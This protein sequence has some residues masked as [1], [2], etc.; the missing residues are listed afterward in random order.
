MRNLI[1]LLLLSSQLFAQQ[2][3]RIEVL[4]LGDNGHHVPIERIPT[5]MAALGPKG[6]NFTYTDQLED[7]NKTTLSKYD[8]LMIFANW[9][10]ISSEQEKALLDFVASGKG[11]LPIHCASY[12][13]RNSNEYVKLVGGQFWR[14]TMDSIT[15]TTIK[16]EHPI[17]QGLSSFTAY[18]ETYLHSQLQADNNVLATREIKSDQYKDRP[19]SKTEPY[20]WTRTYGKGKI[21]YTAYGHDERTWQKTGFQDLLYNAI[22]WSVNDEAR[23]A[24]SN[25][26]PTPFEYREA[27]LPNYEQRPGKQLQQLPLSPEESMK[28][29]QVPV[30]FNI[31]TFAAEPNVM[32]PIAISWDE[33]GRMFVLI[34]KDYPNERK[35]TGGSDYILICEDTDKDGKA[36]K[37]T[38]FAEGL[39]IPTG[40]V[41]ANGGLIVSQA[42]DMLFLKDTDGDDKA[43]VKKVLF[44]GFGTEDTHAG[45]SNLHYGF[46]NW[47]WGCVGYSGFKGKFEGKDT[48]DFGQAFFRFKADGSQLEWMTSTSN[49]TWGFA[50]NETN[51]VFGSTANN[52]HGW[53]MA[54]PNSYFNSANRI[55]N[56]SRST[57]THR[58]M[59][60]I[61][62]KVRQVDA[63]GGFT[64][65]AGQNFYT[66]RSFPKK[67][68]NKIAFVSEPTGHVLHQNTMIKKG[69]DFSDA[70]SFNLLASADEWVSPVFAEVGPDGAVWVADWYSYIIQ[71]NPVPQ[72]YDNGEGNAYVTDLRD[73]THGRIYRISYKNA[74]AYSPISLSIQYADELLKALKSD[75]MFWRMHAQRL[76]VE[77]GQKDIVPALIEMVKDQ[78]LDE[79][80]IN[81]AGIHALWTLKGLNALDNNT[82]E[83]A[84]KHPSSDMRKNAIKAMEFN[85]ASVDL[86]LKYD[87]LNDPEKLVV[88]NALLLMSKS[89]LNEIAENRILSRLNNANETD[90]RWLPDA[91]SCVLTANNSKLL[92]K[93]LAL[94]L[95]KKSD[96]KNEIANM[97][98]DH[99][100]MGSKETKNTATKTEGA[101]LVV[102]DI[103][104]SPSNPAVRE[105]IYV[106][107][108]VT[109][110]GKQDIA[111]DV[112][113]PLNIRFEGMG[114]KIDQVSRNFKDGIKS[115]ETVSITKNINGP[116]I[117]NIS[118]ATD[119]VGT[120]NLSVGID[121]NNEIVESN[122]KNN[123]F[124]KKIEF[125]M[126][127]SLKA[128]AIE[129][130][131]RSYASIA[132][133]DSLASLLKKS[134]SLN[135]NTYESVVKAISEGWNYKSTDIKINPTNKVYLTSIS[136]KK[137][138][139]LEK[140][141]T[142]WNI[143]AAAKPSTDVK[144]I[145]IKT[146]KE[147]MKYDIR[148][149]TVK[150]GQT[151]E[152]IFENVDAMQHNMVITKPNMLSKVGQAG[153]KMMKDPKG[154]EKNY[155]PSIPEVLF[156]TPL[157]NPG[158]SYKLTFKAPAT[159]GD[160]PYVCTF[161]GH[162]TLMNGIMKVIPK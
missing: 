49:N 22:L 151:V 47:I 155:V 43:D 3:R 9:D 54:I 40:M 8:A 125:I 61:T 160:Y 34:T 133:A 93:Q 98:H 80:G 33:K 126:P 73:F 150:A 53:Y 36:D 84:L 123:E 29:I 13:F 46:D 59:K 85:A 89:P 127:A 19:A 90:D 41:F 63:F 97:N 109:N 26:N 69:T 5:L 162:W 27:K 114:M 94:E 147:A 82:I 25:R 12:C 146:I 64:A 44:S 118:F 35:S 108:E 4:F 32:H 143:I 91:F 130:A 136:K 42:P 67:Y 62:E 138:E 37:F 129:R 38:K 48:L 16:P 24:F 72:G 139:R 100:N 148:S 124:N 116:W 76:L 52:S 30:D 104:I 65:A 31:E 115:G 144:T 71:H 122:K 106:T 103:K 77:R 157:I 154:A 83:I 153:D 55:E 18:D 74:K 137:D 117:G 39:S 70:E 99:H 120:Y 10:S 140:L 128:Y 101:D 57:D 20:T 45:P 50:F 17:M 66:A 6:I 158:K 58:D 14:H 135:A 132:T 56:G 102:S 15:T 75:N 86:I 95:I 110:I 87:L 21:F 78:N 79:I 11:F 112:F 119:I 60:P 2:Q 88:M 113:I 7:L 142:A 152:I 23:S 1:I 92:K 161:P 105:R 68:W 149:F 51:D 121:R 81:A 145:T 156:S 141:L 28:H 107:V 111:K 134:A 159:T 96:D 131:I